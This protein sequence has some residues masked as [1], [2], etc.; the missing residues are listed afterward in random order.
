MYVCICVSMYRPSSFVVAPTLQTNAK[1][2]YA[3][4][5]VTKSAIMISVAAGRPSTTYIHTYIHAGHKNITQ[6]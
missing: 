4:M 2:K 5:Q 3:S 6:L 1:M